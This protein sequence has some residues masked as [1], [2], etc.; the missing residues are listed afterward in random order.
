[1]AD[2]DDALAQWDR[3]RE[4]AHRGGSLLGILT[5][6]LW[7]GFTLLW[8]GELLDAEES[9]TGVEQDFLSWGLV[10]SS[11]TYLPAFLGLIRALRGDLDG[12]R[13][14]LDPDKPTN[15]EGDGY[16]HLLNGWGEL[17]LLEGR[18]DEALAVADD[19]ASQLSFS[20]HPGWSP[21]RSLKA[22]ALAGLGRVDEALEV[23]R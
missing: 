7:R 4:R 10:Q 22:R 3:L 13:A 8:R 2:L 14:M 18:Y 5:V 20:V 19:L 23:A 12:A 16:R 6:G 1:M 17:L 11:E 21:W 9:L 15:R